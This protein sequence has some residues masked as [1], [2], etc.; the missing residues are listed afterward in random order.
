MSVDRARALALAAGMAAVAWA[1]LGSP[2]APGPAAAAPKNAPSVCVGSATFA[3]DALDTTGSGVLAIRFR[4][5]CAARPVRIVYVINATREVTGARAAFLLGEA[6]RATLALNLGSP[7]ARRYV[8]VAV[9][10]TAGVSARLARPFT[11]DITEILSFEGRGGDTD[12]QCLACALQLAGEVLRDERDRTGGA[13]AEFVALF[14]DQGEEHE[15]DADGRRIEAAAREL[16]QSGIAVISANRRLASDDAF[17]VA[18]SQSPTIVFRN[19]GTYYTRTDL[20]QLALELDLGGAR[21]Q[22]QTDE[23][24]ARA[25]G[26][27]LT[28]A[29]EWPP[30]DGVTIALGLDNVDRRPLSVT[31]A[32]RLVDARRHERDLEIVH[33][34]AAP[35]PEPSATAGGGPSAT[36][37]PPRPTRTPGP[38]PT[39]GGARR[40]EPAYL[41]HALRDPCARSAR[42]FDVLVVLDISPSARAPGHDFVAAAA[43]LGPLWERALAPETDPVSGDDRQV[44]LLTLG[45]RPELLLPPTGR[46][47]QLAGA[48]RA[49]ARSAPACCTRLDVGLRA[50]RNA[51]AGS[52][53]PDRLKAILL[54]TDGAMHP[55]YFDAVL[56]EAFAARDDGIVLLALGLG[57]LHEA[58]LLEGLAGSGKRFSAVEETDELADAVQRVADLLR[59]DPTPAGP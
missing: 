28:W 43:D 47:G 35:R 27:R 37:D 13:P 44:G 10:E 7:S 54:M 5:D 4:H 6:R 2:A 42:R 57:P 40:P 15:D 14:G 19:L 56:T 11:N 16:A 58:R 32:A 29:F 53:S 45:E 25:D 38:T 22:A 41:P 21:L 34:V 33:R 59:C 24:P 46:R 23:P 3:S 1:A 9:V 55:H 26:N 49:V 8:R 20:A 12:T 52:P 31:L 18:G 50:A 51:L 30:T 17:M 48:L 36:P 39:L